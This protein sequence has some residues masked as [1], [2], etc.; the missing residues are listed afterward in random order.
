MFH[1]RDRRRRV[2]RA[3]PCRMQ[4]RGLRR[5]PDGRVAMPGCRFGAR[6]CAARLRRQPPRLAARAAAGGALSVVA[7]TRGQDPVAPCCCVR[8]APVSRRPAAA[9]PRTGC[10]SA[11]Q[12]TVWGRAAAGRPAL[13]VRPTV[14]SA[15]SPSPDPRRAKVAARPAALPG[16]NWTTER[17]LGR[18][19]RATCATQRAGPV[20][21]AAWLPCQQVCQRRACEPLPTTSAHAGAAGEPVRREPVCL[22]ARPSTSG[23]VSYPARWCPSQRPVDGTS[24]IENHLPR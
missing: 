14:P 18:A 8:P 22:R 3:N 10:R 23:P 15:T 16:S 1:R 17:T 19:V 20:A 4:W 5:A 12:D 6:P 21:A 7:K 24:G 13:S 2:R 9:S 11:P